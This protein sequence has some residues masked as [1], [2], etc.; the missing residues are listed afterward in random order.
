MKE[1]EYLIKEVDKLKEIDKYLVNIIGLCDNPAYS[2]MDIRQ[3]AND[4]CSF[5]YL[6]EK[7]NG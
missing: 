4:A 2:K 3:V 1:F 5:L 6:E 7:K